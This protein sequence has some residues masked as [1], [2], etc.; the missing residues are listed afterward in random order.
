MRHGFHC[1]LF[2][3]CAWVVTPRPCSAG[4]TPV[5]TQSRFYWNADVGIRSNEAWPALGDFFNTGYQTSG[6]FGIEVGN[7]GGPDG[8][9]TVASN[10]TDWDSSVFYIMPTLRWWGRGIFSDPYYQTVGFRLGDAMFS[11]GP[12]TAAAADYG[13]VYRIQQMF[14]QAFDLGFEVGYDYEAFPGVF[15]RTVDVSGISTK[16]I[17]G[18]WVGSPFKR[19]PGDYPFQRTPEDYK[20]LPPYDATMARNIA[21]G[22]LGSR[23]GFRLLKSK[24]YKE[25][26][27][28]FMRAVGYDPAN[29]YA[30]KGLGNACYYQGDKAGAL[31]AYGKELYLEPNNARLRVFVERYKAETAQ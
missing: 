27:T 5:Q 23:S 29:A 30:W 3:L 2:F 14:G 13:I 18:T 10:T 24:R 28:E 9:I 15:G 25:A 19:T 4:A 7:S 20:G 16:L 21:L 11:D 26:E 1:V 17:L 12:V 22:K 6:L 8:S 31:S